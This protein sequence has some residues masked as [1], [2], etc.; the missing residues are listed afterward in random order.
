[1]VFA[2]PENEL[3]KVMI[4]DYYGI[5]HL[6]TTE[7]QTIFKMEIGFQVVPA[8]QCNLTLFI[9]LHQLPS[10]P[11]KVTKGKRKIGR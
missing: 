7:T 8:S 9:E 5:Q 11:K 4:N 6:R 10:S 2:W 1:M 3:K